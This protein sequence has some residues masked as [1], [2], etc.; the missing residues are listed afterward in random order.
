MNTIEVLLK[1]ANVVDSAG[2]IFPLEELTKVCNNI[3]ESELPPFGEFGIGK[4][5]LI[6]VDNISHTVVSARMDGD[7]LMVTINLLD[8]PMGRLAQ[9]CK[10]DKLPIK[11]ALRSVGFVDEETKLVSRLQFI[12]ADIFVFGEKTL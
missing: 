3:N 10:N 2:R 6:T 8:T 11:G 1:Q 4:D 9:K 12:T 7:K 5:S